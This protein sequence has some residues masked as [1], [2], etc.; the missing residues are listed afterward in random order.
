MKWKNQTPDLKSV[1]ILGWCVEL[2]YSAVS[3]YFDIIEDN[4][5]RQGKTCWHKLN[6]VGIIGLN[7]AI[8][9]ENSIYFLMHKYFKNSSNY[10]P[11][12][13]IFH[14]A[15]L[16]SACVQSTTLL[17][18]KQPVT[19]FSMEMYKMIANAKTANYLFELPFRLAMQM[20]G[21]NIQDASHLYTIIL[22]EM[23]HL[24]QVQDDFLNLYG[25]SEK[26]AKNGSDIARN[27]CT[28]FAVEF[29]RRANKEQKLTMQ[30]CYGNKGYC[31]V[32]LKR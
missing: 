17:S 5:W 28:W 23:G 22:H 19:S 4:G 8:I 10:V 26:Y 3:I 1:E 32:Q 2:L 21:I 30:R 15:A 9:L 24:Y 29:M 16:K 11:L 20:A 13:Q 12:M 14:D 7:D 27:K 25:C 31:M 6:K 18:C